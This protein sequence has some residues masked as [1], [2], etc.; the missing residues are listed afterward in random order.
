MDLRS[1]SNLIPSSIT[2]RPEIDGLR[3]LAVS[4]VILYH[5]LPKVYPGGFIGVDIFFVISG[6]LIGSIFCKQLKEGY[7]SLY[8]FYVGRILRL[9]PTLIFTVGAVLIFGYF[10]LVTTDFI[11]LARSAISGLLF[12]ENIY[13]LNATDYFKPAASTLPLLHLWSLSMEEQFYLLFPI[14]TV[15]YIKRRRFWFVITIS[16]IAFSVY[17]SVFHSSYFSPICRFWEILSGVLFA[18]YERRNVHVKPL[19]VL[20]INIIYGKRFVSVSSIVQL[21]LIVILILCGILISDQSAYPGYLSLIPVFASIFL[22]ITFEAPS[23]IKNFFTNRWVVYV[24]LISYPLYMVHWPVL[25]FI[26]KINN[27]YFSTMSLLCAFFLTLILSSLIYHF[28]ELPIRLFRRRGVAAL[29]LIFFSIFIIFTCRAINENNGLPA[30]SVNYLNQA[31]DKALNYD[32]DKGFRHNIC[33]IDALNE[34]TSKF[35]DICT[36][37]TN[38]D[39]PTVVLWGDSHAASLY[40][41]LE[42]R[43]INDGYSL[44]QFTSSGCPPVIDFNVNNRPF[45]KKINDSVIKK[46]KEIHP[47]FVVISAFWAGYNGKIN[48]DPTGVIWEKIDAVKLRS[49]VIYLKKIGVQKIVV[50]GSLPAYK[51]RQPDLLM[52]TFPFQKLNLRNYEML[53]Q[54]IFSF[55]LIVKSSVSNYG[56]FIDPLEKLCNLDGCLLSSTEEYYTPIAFDYGHL[57]ETGSKFIVKTIFEDRLFK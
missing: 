5:A 21:L 23:A 36:D 18:F 8:K 33:F 42:A 7:F 34:K 53:N 47:K 13:L 29:T 39:R 54:D 55:N 10:T 4:M 24:G 52:R 46:I 9:F 15:L 56:F 22:I 26:K 48:D 40:R 6:Y 14:I 17:A 3:A 35:N 43:S 37:S 50:V 2:Y 27:G 28:I 44:V 19:K 11:S 20:S 38:G 45:C 30:R 25:V 32:A 31:I 12:Y 16:L 41:G 49:T 1:S 57:T 51:I